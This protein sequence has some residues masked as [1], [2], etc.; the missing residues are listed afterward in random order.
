MNLTQPPEGD[1]VCE[2]CSRTPL[3]L[4]LGGPLAEDPTDEGISGGYND[5]HYASCICATLEQYT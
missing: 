3:Q 5:F 2:Q 4:S 1:W